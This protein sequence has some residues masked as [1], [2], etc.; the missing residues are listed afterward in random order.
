MKNAA[1]SNEEKWTLRKRP[2]IQTVNDELKHMPG[3][4]H[5]TLLNQW[6]CI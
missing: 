1:L 4:I 5:E 6:V 2:V 3:R